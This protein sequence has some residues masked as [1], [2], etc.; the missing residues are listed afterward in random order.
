[1][2]AKL[3]HSPFNGL[4]QHNPNL[5]LTALPPIPLIDSRMRVSHSKY[6]Y[7]DI[8]IFIYSRVFAILLRTLSLQP[9]L[10]I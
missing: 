8:C 3:A 2:F 4:S 1:M 6:M 10:N 5:I 9:S 7:V